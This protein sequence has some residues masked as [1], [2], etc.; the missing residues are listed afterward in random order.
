MPVVVDVTL[1]ERAAE[2]VGEDQAVLDPAIAGELA[3]ESHSLALD[4]DRRDRPLRQR[5]DPSASFGLDVVEHDL[6]LPVDLAAIHG[7][8]EP[9]GAGFQVDLRPTEARGLA[10]A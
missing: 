7:L 3:G 4:V 9:D 2:R 1:V 6:E 8:A 10:E 5:R